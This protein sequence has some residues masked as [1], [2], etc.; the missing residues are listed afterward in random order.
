MSGPE[1]GRFHRFGFGTTRAIDVCRDCRSERML[2]EPH[3]TMGEYAASDCPFGEYAGWVFLVP[4]GRQWFK[5]SPDCAIV[6][7]W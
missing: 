6:R 3:S 1:P 7:S 2:H 5:E 4:G